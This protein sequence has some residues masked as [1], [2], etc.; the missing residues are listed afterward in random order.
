VDR[1][2]V[3]IMALSLID[4]YGQFTLRKSDE[5]APA[6]DWHS[7]SLH[8]W[9]LSA[10]RMLPVYPIQCDGEQVGWLMGMTADETGSLVSPALQISSLDHVEDS[11]YQLGGRY[12]CVI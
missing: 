7:Q 4:L 8:S 10:H 6:P 11:I 5:Q 12:A 9:T 1:L 3:A 2:S